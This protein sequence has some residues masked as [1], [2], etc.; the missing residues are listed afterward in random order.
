M[1]LS[2]LVISYVIVSAAISVGRLH[3]QTPPAA[4]TVNQCMTV[5]AGFEALR[6]AGA[7]LNDQRPAPPDARQYKLG[8]VRA[9]AAFSLSK[10]QR[11][12]DAF[13]KARNAMAAELAADKANLDGNN[14]T[15]AAAANLNQAM[16][17]VLDGPCDVQLDR[18]KLADLRL[19]DEGDRN[20]I[21]P[22]VVAALSPIID[23]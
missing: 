12:M 11:V 9:I 4:L 20:Q 19:G 23:R 17:K 1:K 2:T 7:Q 8:E 6:Y 18:I 3:A 10:L 22:S 14:F 13:A 5:N 16:Q 21:P 15:P